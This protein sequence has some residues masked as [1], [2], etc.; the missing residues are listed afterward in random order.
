MN[1]VSTQARE[2][3]RGCFEVAARVLL[4][5]AALAIGA[6]SGET[7]HHYHDQGRLCIYP[8]GSHGDP[9]IGAGVSYAYPADV[10]L[11][12][13]VAFKGCL[14]GSCSRDTVTSCSVAEVDGELRVTSDGSYVDLGKDSCTLDC[15][16]FQATCTTPVLA[17]GDHLLRHGADTLSL[18]LPSSRQ[19]LCVGEMAGD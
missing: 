18:T 17:G 6:C 3:F 16:Y 9:T 7:P 5:L 8:P 10:A 19:V 14:S 2:S 4:G 12:V 15:T 1:D 13:V 11:D